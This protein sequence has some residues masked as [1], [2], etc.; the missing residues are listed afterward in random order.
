MNIAQL[1]KTLIMNVLRL[2]RPLEV[3]DGVSSYLLL[4][5]NKMIPRGDRLN[6]DRMD[7]SS[8]KYESG[9]RTDGRVTKPLTF[10]NPP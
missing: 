6:P 3:E 8:A 9:R 10:N 5:L 1:I 2:L 7:L 4:I